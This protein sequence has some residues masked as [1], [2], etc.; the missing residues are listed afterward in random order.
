MLSPET[1]FRQHWLLAA[2]LPVCWFFAVFFSFAPAGVQ[3]LS[4]YCPHVVSGDSIQTSSQFFSF[5]FTA[6]IF[7]RSL[8][9][10]FPR[11]MLSQ[12]RRNVLR[13][14]F[15]KPKLPQCCPN[16]VSMLS[17]WCPW[18]HWNGYKNKSSRNRC[19]LNVVPGDNF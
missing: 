9:K 14:S 15:Q 19:C 13:T 4:Q 3:M 12:C 2:I 7:Q 18:K 1:I 11:P 16:V 17:Q 10:S 5:F 8:E 6:V